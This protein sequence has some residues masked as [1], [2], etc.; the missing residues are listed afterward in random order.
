[1]KKI[2]SLE[3]RNAVLL[4]MADL[5][6]QEESILLSANDKDLSSFESDDIA[7]VDRLKVNKKKVGEMVY[8]LKQLAA[9]DDP[10][11]VE[12]F[13]FTHDNGLEISNK[14]APFGTIL[15]IYES[16]PD[17]TIE[18]AG[19]AFKS[20]NKILLKG[21]KESLNSNLVLVNLWHKALEACD[22][23]KDW[24]TYLNF[25]REETQKF[26][27][28]PTEKLDLIVPRGGERLI[29]FVKQYAQCPV[30]V[31][32]RGNNFVYVSHEADLQMALDI[33]INAKTT[34]ISAC[35]A[36]DK[37][38]ISRD[39]PR[40]MEFLN[41]LVQSLKKYNVEILTD[42]KLAG[43]E[44]TSQM[45]DESVWYEE[46]LD[47]KIVIGQ[48]AD[49]DEAIQHINTH[50][51]GHSA[52]IITKNKEEADTFMQSVDTAAVYHNAS[53]RFTDGGQFG[54]G[55]ELAIST[56]KLHQRGPIG[57]QHLVTNKWFVKGNGQIR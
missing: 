27:E 54:L 18:A 41:L 8:S 19:I 45:D 13:Q 11:H 33:I 48:V 10:L 3:K 21:G 30:I 23:A 9:L 36:A 34:K 6:R 14:T 7:M 4:R 16:R 56:D 31:S 52:A 24:I 38:I 44:G 28:K 17:V 49:V 50:G 32:G 20:G 35:N 55:G 26:L 2:L 40:K 42:A 43:L 39:L 22:C 51:G 5:V 15:I 47:Y 1:M 12:R 53:T 37:V 46:F 57:L 29:S 25:S